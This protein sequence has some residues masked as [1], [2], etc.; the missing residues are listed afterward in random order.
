M[1]ARMTDSQKLRQ[2]SQSNNW[3][4]V[5]GAIAI[6]QLRKPIFPINKITKADTLATIADISIIK[7][8]VDIILWLLM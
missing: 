2:K 7:C 4:I 6:S 3:E 5:L 8:T 1:L